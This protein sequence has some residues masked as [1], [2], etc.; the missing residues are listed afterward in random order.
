MKTA[1][2]I[3][4]SGGIGK[5]AAVTL[6]ERG[7]DQVIV[8]FS[9]DEGAIVETVDAV[10]RVG[11][12]PI[13]ARLDVSDQD[14]LPIFMDVLTSNSSGHV[15]ALVYA[16]GLR[17]LSPTLVTDTE[18]NRALEVSLIGFVRSVQA[19]SSLMTSGGK[20]VGVS[21]ISGLRAY[22]SEHM[23]MGTVKAASHHSMKYLAWELARRGINLNM[24]CFG[25]VL[26]D[27]VKRDL[28]PEQYAAFIADDDRSL[29]VP[30]GFVPE[31]RDVAK[32]IA[33]LCSDDAQLLV[34]QVIVADGGETLR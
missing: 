28:T 34:G 2:V 10:H 9:S 5:A 17:V 3:G 1:V 32:V 18:W 7:F 16:A 11:A 26:T 33:F 4:G 29:R 24:T 23:V 19:I 25:A 27:G 12:N 21:G 22:S 15:D 6:A 14:A 30:L 31:P 13:S 8:T 20:I